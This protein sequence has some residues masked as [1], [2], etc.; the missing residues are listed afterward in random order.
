[1]GMGGRY[2]PFRDATRTRRRLWGGQG[3]GERKVIERTHPCCRCDQGDACTRC[4]GASPPKRATHPHIQ[5]Q[6]LRTSSLAT[7]LRVRR[8][9][10]HRLRDLLIHYDVDLHT[11]LRLAFEQAVQAPFLVERGR[12]TEIQLGREPP[13]LCH[14]TSKQGLDQGPRKR[15][16]MKMH[17]RALS[18]ISESAYM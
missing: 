6:D 7:Y 1:M 16:R 9:H 13:V 10:R 17:S 4:S 5:S 11:L 15:T 2:G 3:A 14:T 18:R 12:A 8:A